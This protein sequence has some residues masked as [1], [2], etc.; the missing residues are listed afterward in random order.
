M[1]RGFG[2]GVLVGLGAARGRFVGYLGSDGQILPE[3]VVRAFWAVQPFP[4]G[5]V[6]TK[7]RRVTRG[8]GPIRWLVTTIY[9]RLFWVLFGALTD[10]VNG[11]PKF[12][13]REDLATLDLG[14][15]DWFLDA[16]VMIKAKRLG[17]KLV[18]VPVDFLPRTRGRSSVR[19]KTL[20]EFL[21]NLLRWRFGRLAAWARRRAA[22]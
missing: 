11:T 10:D 20:F 7:V 17:W 9:N 14:S 4:Q 3:D 1:N 6:V 19:F 21:K 13:L 5:K 18:E 22:P 12:F 16:E 8:D 2:W 15:E